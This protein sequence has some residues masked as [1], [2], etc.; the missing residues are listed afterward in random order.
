MQLICL[1][2]VNILYTNTLMSAADELSDKV[3][4]LV[5]VFVSLFVVAPSYAAGLMGAVSVAQA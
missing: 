4:V 1:P 2:L 3:H 5:L